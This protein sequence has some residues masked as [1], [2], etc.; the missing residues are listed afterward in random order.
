MA[1][2]DQ[3]AF[4]LAMSTRPELVPAVTSESTI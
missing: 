2:R 3:E 1:R 4:E